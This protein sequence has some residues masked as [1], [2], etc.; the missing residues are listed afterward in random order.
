MLATD[1]GF[2][3]NV[4]SQFAG[5][6]GHVVRRHSK[7]GNQNLRQWNCH[8]QRSFLIEYGKM[9]IVP[10]TGVSLSTSLSYG[11]CRTCSSAGDRPATIWY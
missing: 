10:F 9:G 4:V 5:D 8:H 11:D 3:R 1:E 6:E 7:G 2:R